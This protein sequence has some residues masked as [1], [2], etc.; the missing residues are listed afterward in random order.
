MEF[1]FQNVAIATGSTW[2]RDG[3][4]RF[5]LHPLVLDG[6][7]DIFTPDDLM[8]GNLPSGRVLVYDDD[9]Y[10]MGGVLTEL[11]VQNGCSVVFA[12]PSAYVSEWARNTFEQHHVQSNFLEWGVDL[13]LSHGLTGIGGD[14]VQ[15]ACTYTGNAVEVEVDAV[16]LVTS[17]LGN[18]G[19]WDD[20][21]SRESDW[22]D[23]GIKT[24]KVFGDAQSPAPIAW[25]TYAGHRY[26]RE[27]DEPDIG[28]KL[29]FRR[30]IT[31]LEA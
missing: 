6:A 22:A 25:A 14:S 24:I 31:H 18:T 8:A 4:A 11:L 19:L 26:A 10:Y 9:H 13:R 5:L 12:T 27:L 28:D 15:L 16:L 20:L 2:R 29:P 7:I 1:G 23:A 30:E 17:R 21:S 3:V